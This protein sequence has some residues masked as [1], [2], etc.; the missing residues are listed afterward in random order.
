MLKQKDIFLQ[1]EGDAWYERN[2]QAL[3]RR[4]LPADD[5]VIPQVRH[6]VESCP[7]RDADQRLQLLEVGCGDGSR[8]AWLQTHLPVRVFGLD[9]S[10]KAVAACARHGVDAQCG[11][12]DQLPY[13]DGRF[14]ILVF[15]FC[16][17]LCDDEDLFRIAAE[18]NRVLKADAWLIIHDFFSK[19]PA[20]RDYHHRNGVQTRK[21]DA[22]SIFNWH[23]S[24]TCVH[25][26]IR[27]HEHLGHTDDRDEWVATQLL[28]KHP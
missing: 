19:A 1:G 21:M 18:A 5:P 13:D 15:G 6:V 26:I 8:L 4:A 7:E 25:S 9:P 10:R 14:D 11:T 17:Y 27:H 28:R 20:R 3:E 16:L 2:V 23:P 24:Y 12:A 22:A